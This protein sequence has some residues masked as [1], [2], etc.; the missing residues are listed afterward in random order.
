MILQRRNAP[1]DKAVQNWDA[2]IF[3]AKA[4]FLVPVI[5]RADGF[6]LVH[7]HVL[8]CKQRPSINNSRVV[9]S[10]RR[11][12]AWDY[13]PALGCESTIQLLRS[14][15]EASRKFLDLFLCLKGIKCFQCPYYKPPV[16][17]MINFNRQYSPALPS[18][19]YW[20]INWEACSTISKN[21]VT[22]CVTMGRLSLESWDFNVAKGMTSIMDCTRTSAKS[23]RFLCSRRCY[24]INWHQTKLGC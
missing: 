5:R 18:D 24:P 14:G 10:W 1:W 16:S 20:M 23:S 6:E 15:F 13:F 21:S 4:G 2:G 19:L 9:P 8:F 12:K 17:A 11:T 3:H 7:E 22:L